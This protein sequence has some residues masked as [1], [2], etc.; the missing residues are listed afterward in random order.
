MAQQSHY[1]L[2]KFVLLKNGKFISQHLDR[3][4]G[5][6][7]KKILL[8]I[9]LLSLTTTAYSKE[10]TTFVA[11]FSLEFIDGD[12]T[13][14]STKKDDVKE[15]IKQITQDRTNYQYALG[16]ALISTSE[17]PKDKNL[18]RGL[19]L[20]EDETGL[21]IRSFKVIV[22]K[23]EDNRAECAVELTDYT[24]INRLTNLRISCYG[25]NGS[26]IASYIQS[27]IDE[28]RLLYVNKDEHKLESIFSTFEN[29]V[30]INP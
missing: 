23:L 8:V 4:P 18:H 14:S 11:Q 17:L 26:A 20:L 2:R 3:Y 6:N 28:S 10:K 24:R 25:I 12:K 27:N 16:A 30:T 29:A 5:A 21:R 15:M 9:G 22:R 13:L 1:L 7:M 19:Q